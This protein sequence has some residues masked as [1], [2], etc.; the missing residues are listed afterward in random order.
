M[1]A[2]VAKCSLQV[3]LSNGPVKTS[4]ALHEV[5]EARPSKFEQQ[6]NLADVPRVAEF[7]HNLKNVLTVIRSCGHLMARAETDEG[8]RRACLDTIFQAVDRGAALTGDLIYAQESPSLHEINH[9][10]PFDVRTSLD[11]LSALLSAI[12]GPEV[13]VSFDHDPSSDLLVQG[14]PKQF[15][16]ALLNLVANARDAMRGAGEVT[17]KVRVAYAR[18][19]DG[20]RRAAVR[21]S[22]RDTG[23]GIAPAVRSRIFEPFFTTR[24]AERGTGIG[25]AQVSE[26]VRNS[27]GRLTVRTALGAGSTFTLHLRPMTLELPGAAASRPMSSPK[28]VRHGGALC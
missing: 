28:S 22:V 16:S 14:N 24:Q 9:S 19:K 18:I 25:L 26:F 3:G 12:A 6:S 2:R 15:D 11:G 4:S 1:T 10:D 23:E 20:K 13:T 8:R 7:A 17:I 27:G 21:I 5:R